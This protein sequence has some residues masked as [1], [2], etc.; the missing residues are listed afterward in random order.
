M[1]RIV[2]TDPTQCAG[3]RRIQNGIASGETKKQGSRP[4]KTS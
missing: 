3:D 2:G 4:D 1:V